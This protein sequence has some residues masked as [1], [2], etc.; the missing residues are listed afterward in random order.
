MG[1]APFKFGIRQEEIVESII[2]FVYE[3]LC[4][5]RDDPK[6]PNKE[7]EKELNP[8]L[9]KILTAYAHKYELG[10]NFSHEE[11]QEGRHTI[12]FSVCYDNIDLYNEII[13]VFECKRLTKAIGGKRTDEYVTGHK[14]RTG[15][16]QRFKLEAHGKKHKIVGMIGYIQSGSCFE[17]LETI[18]NCIDNLSDINQMETVFI[19]IKANT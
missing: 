11:P 19:G 5:W 7:S 10:I 8:D 15:G 3:H 14:D 16:I 4:K 18:N 1:F 13:T 9:P 17:W 12:D 2:I 6:R